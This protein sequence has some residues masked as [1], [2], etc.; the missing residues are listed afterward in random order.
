MSEAAGWDELRLRQ[1]GDDLEAGGER[2]PDVPAIVEDEKRD[3]AGQ[4]ATRDAQIGPGDVVAPLEPLLHRVAYGG[5]DV[6]DPR[7][8]PGI[9]FQIGSRG[10]QDE[11][12]R[13]SCRERV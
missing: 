5:G 13:A 9:F 1:A 8:A 7:E 11:I 12:G 4:R 6:E 3:F 10:E 2:H